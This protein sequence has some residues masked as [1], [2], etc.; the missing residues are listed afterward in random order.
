MSQQLSVF[1]LG[2]SGIRIPIQIYTDSNPLLDSIA[3]TKQVEQRL[4]RNTITDLNK[5]GDDIGNIL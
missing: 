4:L 3:S 2:D 1:L 5:E